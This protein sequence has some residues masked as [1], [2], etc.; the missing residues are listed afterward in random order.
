MVEVHEKSHQ[1]V[2]LEDFIK[3][4]KQGR[5]VHLTISLGKEIIPRRI[6]VE[7]N[8]GAN[9]E[10]VYYF[11]ACYFLKVNGVTRIITKKLAIGSIGE[12]AAALSSNINIANQ[13][14]QREY[15]RLTDVNIKFKEEYF[16]TPFET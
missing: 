9:A 16:L 4:G 10:D 13:C 3:L 7:P 15:E 8:D 14:L 5:N 12:S 1:F 11:T 2:S 6:P